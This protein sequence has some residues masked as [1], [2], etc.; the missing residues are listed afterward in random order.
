MT[1]DEIDGVTH[2]P[3]PAWLRQLDR[4]VRTRTAQGS[5]LRYLAIG[6]IAGG[7][8][9]V[10]AVSAIGR[11]GVG[12]WPFDLL[13][14]FRLQYAALLVGGTASLAVL[15]CRRLA[16]ATGAVAALHLASLA[17]LVIGAS[18]PDGPG[19]SL[20]VVQFNVLTINDR[21]D[22]AAR[23]LAAQDADVIVA[24]ETDQRWADGLTAGLPGWRALATDTVRSD[25]FGMLIFVRDGLEVG[26]VDVI[27]RELPA[28]TVELAID[29]RS[30]VL[31]TAVHT[32]PPV[33]PDQMEVANE[34]L[35]L[36]ASSVSPHPGPRL[37]VGDL[38][39]T[40]WSGTYRR[41]TDR[42]G[43]RN[44]ADGFGLGG[45]WPTS[46]WYSGAIGIDH[47]LVSGEIRV[48]GWE[49]GPDLGSDHRPVVTDLVITDG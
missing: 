36:A 14:N 24:Q 44:A 43:L 30:P 34:Q 16:M 38:N 32:V 41:V 10:T 22:D 49:T 17:P 12:R 8:G 27:D 3:I 48:D 4:T 37:L 15:R 6:T 9:L 23:W 1:G 35:D 39:A 7:A 31:L 29:G 2:R 45:T 25:N 47:V 42:T 5:E 33:D 11:F 13:A 46:L 21:I 26:I 20:R 40:R 19:P 18:Q 28:I